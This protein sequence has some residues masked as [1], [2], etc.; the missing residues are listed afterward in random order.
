MSYCQIACP[1]LSSAIRG[2][3]HGESSIDFSNP[4]S[5]RLLNRALLKQYYQVDYWDIPA[6]Y[7]CPPIPRRADYLH[8]LAD[9][10]AESYA[11][12]DT[13]GSDD[14]IPFG[15]KV[16]VLDVGMGANCVYPIIGTRQYGWSFIGTDIDPVAVKSAATLAASNP[17]LKGRIDCRVQAKRTEHF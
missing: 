2:N 3:S 13:K 5:V 17:G 1:E 14:T 12:C 6:G 7:L 4:Q 15:K 9:I 10:L 16:T 11:Q 8:Y